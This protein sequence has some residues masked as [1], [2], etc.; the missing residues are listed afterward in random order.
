MEWVEKLKNIWKIALSNST[1]YRHGVSIVPVSSIAEQYY[2]EVKV[3]LKYRIGDIP[4]S[5]KEIGEELHNALL[6]AKKV[7]WK[8]I[9]EGIKSGQTVVVSF[10]LFG[11]VDNFIL[12][13]Q[14]DAI[15]FS[16]GRPVLLVELKTTRGRV[17]V[18][19]KDEVVQAQLYALLLD[20]IGFDCSALNMVIV[21]LK[22]D[23]PLTVM[24]KKGFLENIIKA[25]SIG[26]LI[27]IKGKLAIRKIKYSKERALDYVRWAREYW[28]NM[29][30]PIPTRNK[31]KCAVC[32]YRK[33][34]KYAVGT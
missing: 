16:R 3:D 27:K 28:L 23:Q 11:I 14:P 9:V 5:E 21:K 31:K 32:E 24:E 6:P 18:V 8:K 34:C 19:W 29:R 20:L 30:N 4:T 22:R 2:C 1:K 12:G 33:Y 25:C 7:S 15:V 17:N 10:P 26:S 13:G